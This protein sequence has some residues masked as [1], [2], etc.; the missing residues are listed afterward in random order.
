MEITSNSYLFLLIASGALNKKLT[1]ADSTEVIL[2]GT[3]S[4]EK[5]ATAQRDEKGDV[6]K[7]KLVDHYQTVVYG[8]DLTHGQFVKFA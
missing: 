8:L 1:L 3:S 4:K 7:V 6:N 2:K 5:L